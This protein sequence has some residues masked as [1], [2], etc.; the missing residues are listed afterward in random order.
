MINARRASRIVAHIA[1]VRN[2]LT[3]YASHPR[4]INHCAWLVARDTS[5]DE[6]RTK[7]SS[8]VNNARLARVKSSFRNSAVPD[9]SHSQNN[10]F[11]YN[12]ARSIAIACII[13]TFF[14]QRSNVWKDI[15]F[16]YDISQFTAK[17][18]ATTKNMLRIVL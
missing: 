13:A 18:C 2:A 8:G 12:N 6:E 3:N 7:R 10:L 11:L 5:R 15:Y 9:L 14:S 4:A 16:N 1:T 17:F